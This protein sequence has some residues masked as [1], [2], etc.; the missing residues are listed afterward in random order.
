MSTTTFSM[1]VDAGLLERIDQD[2]AHEGIT[3]TAYILQWL[4]C[5]YDSSTEPSSNKPEPA[6]R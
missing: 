3:R 4:P 2:A 5:Y 6:H 1:R